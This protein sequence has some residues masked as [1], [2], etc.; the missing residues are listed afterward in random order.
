MTLPESIII[1]CVADNS[2]KYLNQALRL[3]QS[4]RWFAGALAESEFHVCVVDDVVPE[5][6]RQYES[7]GALVHVVPRFNAVHPPSNKLRFL[8]LPF[9]ANAERVILLD[10]DTVIVQEPLGL[11]T[12][13][14][15]AA[16]IADL[17]TVT[18][19]V[20]N[21]LFSTFELPLPQACERCTVHGEPIIPYFNAGVLSF[22]QK[23]MAS[24]V[25]EW[26]RINHQLVNRFDLLQHCSEFCE[27]ASLSLA[28]AAC[29]SSYET[30]S[31]RLNFP[32][33]CCDEP[34]ESGFGRTDPVIV[35][36]HW[37][38]D[39]NGMLKASPYPNVNNRIGLFNAR[40]LLE[41]RRRF[42]NRIFW[43]ER[44][45]KNPTLGSGQ[46]SRGLVAS[47]KRGL[48]EHLV[49]AC[50]PTTILDV[51]CGDMFVG[52]I[53]PEEGYTG[54][55][56]SAVVIEGNTVKFPRRKFLCGDLEDLELDKS[57]LIVCF[58]LLIHIPDQTKYQRLV[59][60][61]V[62][63]TISTGAIAAYEDRPTICSEITFFHEPISK[64]LA[65]TGAC[66]V[67]EIGSYNQVRVFQFDKCIS[68]KPAK[69]FATDPRLKQPVFLVGAM[70]SG[71]TLLAELLG[72]SPHIAHCSFEL[73][74]VWSEQGGI[75]MASPK[76]RDYACQECGPNEVMPGMHDRLTEAFLRRVNGLQGKAPLAV[77]L[78]KNPH[79][80]N[81]IL[82]VKS[83]FPD[84]RF[85]WI[86]RH[87]PQVVASI[88]R[89]FVDVHSR[90]STWH[91][92]PLPSDRVRNRCWSAFYSEDQLPQISPERI[93][94]G[95][96]IR[97]LAEYWLESNR[98]VG[99]SFAKL[100]PGDGVL[101]FQEKFLMSPAEEL[102]RLQGA[103]K[104]SFCAEAW[105]YV[106]MD[107]KRN[108]EWKT[109]LSYEELRE[110]IRFVEIRADEI[111]AIF[112]FDSPS[113][114]Y[115]EILNR[116]QI[117]KKN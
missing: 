34:L 105:N 109:L 104:V 111:D 72:R 28:L 71:T 46:G 52:E 110:L 67:R 29:G 53:F 31:N 114:H 108:D 66:N 90:Q 58:D 73:K 22:S 100:D 5:Y 61:C 79:L 93:F 16:K 59:E 8:E 64:T 101:V 88:K 116:Q 36:Y 45:R 113:R 2:I 20:F 47:Y 11:I 50:Q 106:D 102:A 56:I 10:C 65:A 38:V 42:N 81:K 68:E 51:G 32:A 7:Y 112:K 62:D 12:T 85:I 69:S 19:E 18:P 4:W 87:L 96:N 17:P 3:L 60:K 82:L 49:V 15:F 94:P 21:S 76:T 43:D 23:A 37:L 83:L 25:P 30:L 98:A 55:D 26:I 86:Y 107:R 35:H 24:L 115:L 84:A 117:L 95:G 14:D 97:Y 1:G 9:L 13:K 89:L 91:W 40:L 41:R 48:A 75:P 80:C 44:Y 6:R 33:H 78:N 57:D 99:E 77:F 74:D 70:R 92:W 103:L 63:L 27:Q 54:V 39:E